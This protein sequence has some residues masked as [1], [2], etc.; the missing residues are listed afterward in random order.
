MEFNADV[1]IEKRKFI[2]VV[3]SLVNKKDLKICCFRQFQ[4]TVPIIC[5]LFYKKV[6]KFFVTTLSS[7]IHPNVPIICSLFYKKVNKFFV[8]TFSSTMHPPVPISCSLFYKK[9]NKFFVTTI[10]STTH[11]I[12]HIRALSDKFINTK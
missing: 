11:P 9:V 5:S 2:Y 12:V 6:N 3:Y 7:T 4:S 8:T 10:S 1:F